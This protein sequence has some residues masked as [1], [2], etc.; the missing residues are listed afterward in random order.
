M[1]TICRTRELRRRGEAIDHAG[2]EEEYPVSAALPD[3]HVWSNGRAFTSDEVRMFRKMW[4]RWRLPGESSRHFFERVREEIER[5]TRDYVA[6]RWS[7]TWSS[8]VPA[9]QEDNDE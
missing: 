8:T 4:K 5:F 3:W 9:V 1:S 7:P 6:A 2:N